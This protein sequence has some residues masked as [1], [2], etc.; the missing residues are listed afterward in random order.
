MEALKEG[1]GAALAGGEQGA[2]DRQGWGDLEEAGEGVGASTL[3]ARGPGI[4]RGGIDGEDGLEGGISAEAIVEVG[5]VG[6]AQKNVVAG[7]EVGE[8]GVG[9]EG[10]EADVDADERAAALLC[11][12]IVD[13]VDAGRER[14]ELLAGGA[15]DDDGD[16]APLEEVDEVEEQ[17]AASPL[18]LLLGATHSGREA[19]GE[20]DGAEARG[21]RRG[22][23][24]REGVSRR[25]YR[26]QG[27]GG[28]DA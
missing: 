26:G 7:A 20:Q 3:G 8:L 19:A 10:A 27:G 2:G 18:E 1:E 24:G 17:R 11:G 6:V 5:E 9:R 15:D 4:V 25:L 12:G 14:G 16:A 23:H 28:E 22:V 13:A 21:G